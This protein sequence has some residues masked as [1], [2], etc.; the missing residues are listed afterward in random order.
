MTSNPA[1]LQAIAAVQACTPPPFTF[2]PG[3]EPGEIFGEN[4]FSLTVMQKRLP[5]SVYK[6]VL[7]TI[8]KSAPLDPAVADAVASAMKDWA[9]EK[10]ATHYAHVFYPLTGL[11]AEKHDSFLDP[12]GDGTA[13]ASFS[14]KTLVQVNLGAND[15][16]RENVK[17]LVFRGNTFV[18]NL[19]L[20]RVDLQDSLAEVTLLAPGMQIQAGDRVTTRLNP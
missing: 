17:L 20:K 12:V 6:S 19:V 16:V 4:V 7:T 18:A 8:E 5:K 14:G 2:D 9:L 15:R 11:T 10:G 13:L 3:E 1:R